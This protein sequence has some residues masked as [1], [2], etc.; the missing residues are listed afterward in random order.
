MHA[1]RGDHVGTVGNLV[2][3]SFEE[4]HRRMCSDKKWVLNEKRLLNLA[5]LSEI[6]LPTQSVE[7]LEDEVLRFSL[8]LKT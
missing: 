2:R 8:L 1:R 4:A 5:G 3:A 7:N 6:S